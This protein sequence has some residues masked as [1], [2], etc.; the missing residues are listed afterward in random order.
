MTN[1][2]V[3]SYDGMEDKQYVNTT[4]ATGNKLKSYNEMISIDNE[5]LDAHKEAITDNF[6]KTHGKS[7]VL[8]KSGTL[9][10]MGQFDYCKKNTLCF[11][12]I[13]SKIN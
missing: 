3:S 5:K 2:N 6:E 9:E 4:K 13:F 10:Y 1:S 7:K 12:E 11:L 8:P